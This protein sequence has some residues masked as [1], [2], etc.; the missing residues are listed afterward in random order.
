MVTTRSSSKYNRERSIK[1][2]RRQHGDE[3][4]DSLLLLGDFLQPTSKKRKENGDEV[5]LL[6]S[7]YSS[8]KNSGVP[9]ITETA[10]S[11]T[12]SFDRAHSSTSTTS[13]TTTTATIATTSSSKVNHLLM[14]PLPLQLCLSPGSISSSNWGSDVASSPTIMIDPNS[15]WEKAPPST[16]TSQIA[17]TTT[18]NTSRDYDILSLSPSGSFNTEYGIFP[19]PQYA[20]STSSN[21]QIYTPVGSANMIN[22]TPSSSPSSIGLALT[23]H[24]HV[25]TNRHQTRGGGASF[26]LP[27]SPPVYG[28]NGLQGVVS[29]PW[30]SPRPPITAAEERLINRI[31]E[32]RNNMPATPL[33]PI[34]VYSPNPQPHFDLEFSSNLGPADFNDTSSSPVQEPTLKLNNTIRRFKELFPDDSG[35]DDDE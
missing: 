19:S 6:T 4:E 12:T 14:S 20:R 31:D 16:P 24:R 10:N 18:T 34:S 30:R 23:P 21:D 33:E 9:M 28:R 15:M 29:S 1:N 27:L 5:R 11:P 13:T 26:I 8:N 3:V 7:Y 35:S 32:T 25:N 2:K 17:T 22:V